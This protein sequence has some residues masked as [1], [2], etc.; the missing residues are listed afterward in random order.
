[1]TRR[2]AIAAPNPS[3]TQA[4][5][6]ALGAGGN[7]VDGA[8]AAMITATAT[9]PG[10]ISPLAGAFIN[11]W[12]A[13]GDPVVIDGN[14]E[15]PGRGADPARFGSGLIECV[16]TYG[17]GL[18]TYAGPGS[19]ATPGM[20]AG[21]GLAHERF[22]AAPWGELLGV[23]AMITADGFQLSH[24]AAS[25]FELVAHTIFAWDP[26]TRGIYTHDATAWAPGH[27]I[28]DD[29]LVATLRQ[30][31]EEGAASVYT[32]DIA[33]RIV[34]DMDERGGLLTARDLA[35]YRPVVRTPLRTTLGAW[36]LSANPPPAIGGAV[37]TAMLRLLGDVK[38]RVSPA[39]AARVMKDV[40]DL[41]LHRVDVADDLEVAGHELLE[42]IASLGAVGLPTSQDTAHVSVVDSDGNACAITASS[43]YGSG[44]SV[45]G[46]GMLGNNALGEPELNRRGLH[47]LAPG[48]RL[49]SNMA[50]TT[51]RH[52][53]GTVLS[54]GT[55]GADRITTALLQVLV[56]FCL[57]GETLQYAVDAPRLHVRH[58]DDGGVRIDFEES[59]ELEEALTGLVGRSSGAV[60]P[61]HAHERRA[62]YF[63]GVGAA[64]RTPEGELTAV[65]DPR[66]DS[67][68]VVG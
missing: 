46:T 4:G 6:H 15:M 30:I 48:T 44:M 20:F 37:L 21:M 33:A 67:A 19:V 51:G 17:G 16:T 2:A 42:T 58:L 26:T 10:I 3:A 8:I 43:G 53:D 54:I 45:G 60:V 25:Y 39:H 49:A 47:A 5:L 36:D 57:H 24:T 23:A 12:P 59:A 63:G 56:H 68:T 32:G 7:A 64:L 61:L 11:I 31:G 41:R 35:E 66:R 1:M 29:A 50:P 9:E 62:M 27:L 34:A 18:T 14:V 38:E 40:L 22:G 13:E 52:R 28:R 55:P 65:A